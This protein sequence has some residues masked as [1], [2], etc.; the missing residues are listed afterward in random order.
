MK[1]WGSAALKKSMDFYYWRHFYKECCQKF[2]PVLFWLL[3]YSVEFWSVDPSFF[4]KVFTVSGGNC[5]LS[6]KFFPSSGLL[7]PWTLLADDLLFHFSLLPALSGGTQN[8]G[9]F[10]KQLQ[11]SL[12]LGRYFSGE[13]SVIQALR[14][15]HRECL[16]NKEGW[17]KCPWFP[18]CRGSVGNSCSWVHPYRAGSAP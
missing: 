9:R 8:K 4:Y 6:S 10:Q 11:N 18:E 7:S 12:F 5:L 17:W 2:L 14:E 3:A 15:E 13:I 16:E 1:L